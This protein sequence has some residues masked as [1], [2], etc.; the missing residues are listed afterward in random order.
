[1]D[2]GEL[3][4]RRLRSRPPRTRKLRPVGP[5]SRVGLSPGTTSRAV[6]NKGLG[7]TEDPN[8]GEVAAR[9]VQRDRHEQRVDAG[10][11]NRAGAVVPAK[12]PP[13]RC[14]PVDLE[15]HASISRWRSSQTGHETRPIML[16]NLRASQRL[17]V[18]RA[19]TPDQPTVRGDGLRAAGAP[20][21][22]GKTLSACM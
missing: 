4:A 6:E 5:G 13:G 15:H 21:Q 8:A 12:P 20:R 10:D 18:P 17:Q 16:W 14:V 19:V 11:L 7:G 9:D 1:M 22:S 3:A 2:R